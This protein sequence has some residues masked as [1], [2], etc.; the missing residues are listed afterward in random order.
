MSMMSYGAFV[1]VITEDQIKKVHPSVALAFDNLTDMLKKHNTD[2]DTVADL[3]DQNDS[4]AIEMEVFEAFYN[5]QMTFEEWSG[6]IPLKLIFLD[7]DR[8]DINGGLDHGANWCVDHS[9]CY[10][11]TPTF[12]FLQTKI[13]K[14]EREFYSISS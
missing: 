9:Y 11:P 12:T 10:M 7:P 3:I 6:G 2:L 8:T 1:E 14:I 4:N 5:L 13:G